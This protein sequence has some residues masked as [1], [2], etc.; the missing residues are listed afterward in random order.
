MKSSGKNKILYIAP[1][2]SSFV[3]SDIALLSKQ[4]R[5]VI[6]TYKWNKK[7]LTP[8][9]LVHQFFFLL[10]HIKTTQSIFVSFGGYWSFLPALLGKMAGVNA[11]IILNGTD[12]A[13]IPPL[14][15]GNL[16]SNPLKW[17]CKQSYKT[18]SKLLPVSASLVSVKNIYFSDDELSFQGYKH[19]F[20]NIKTPYKVIYNGFDE[21]FWK[22]VKTVKK[23]SNTFLAVFSSSQFVLKGGDLIVKLAR[24]FPEYRF[25][26]AGTDTPAFVK[27]ENKN[28]VFLGK[29]SPEKLREYYTR[30]QFYFQLSVFE[31]FG[32]SLAEAMLCECIP[33]GSFVNII[34]EIIG[35][36]GFI[37]E[38]RDLVALEKTVQQALAVED[39][40]ALGQKARARIIAKYPM[41]KREQELFSLV[42]KKTVTTE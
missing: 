20:P 23:E 29:L 22:P 42:E 11:Y 14:Q 28:L 24:K 25:F 41:D 7:W 18:A 35:Q 33:V 27:A 21:N 40:T 12:C 30:A 8:V 34:P 5:V 2:L 9:Y 16:R 10:K 6:N 13:S 26:I 4:Y 39:K 17:F 32:C 36:T 31:G 38:R 1:S 19:F 3:K 15:Y 37:L